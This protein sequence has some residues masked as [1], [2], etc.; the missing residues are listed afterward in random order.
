MLAACRFLSLCKSLHTPSRANIW[1]RLVLCQWST[2]SRAYI[3]RR[4]V[5]CQWST[6]SRAYIWR[7]L[8]LCQWSTH[9]RAYIW[10]RLVLCQWS[11]PSRALRPCL[12]VFTDPRLLLPPDSG[13]QTLILCVLCMQD[14]ADRLQ[15]SSFPCPSCRWPTSLPPGG[16]TGL[17]LFYAHRSHKA[18]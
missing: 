13:L 4:L 1:R 12:G 14:L 6:P 16:A 2:P 18:Y 17:V 3:W 9:S 10:R 5:L 15:G 11:T 8:V 7:R